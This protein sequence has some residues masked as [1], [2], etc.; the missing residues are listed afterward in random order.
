[1]ES[2][3][4]GSVSHWLDGIRR[5]DSQAAQELW[6]RYFARLVTVAR[7]RLMHLERDISGEDVALSAMKSLMMG[8]QE[9]KYPD[10]ADRSG[11][12][13]LLVTITAH[14]SISEQRRQ[15]A[16]KRSRALECRLED[17]QD[18]IGVEPNPEFAVEVADQLENLVLALD[19]STLRQI[20]EKKLAGCTN[21][22]IA[23]EVGCT[24][25]TIIRKL[26][27]IRQEW[28]ANFLENELPETLE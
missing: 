23:E 27:R 21:D 19:D 20:V 5:G 22:Q 4:Q 3:D 6:D 13:P 1:M 12:W 9:D 7:S 8:V 14:K 18:Y 17:V 15:L 11:L 10:L 26:K 28:R 2:N 24:V 25:R 16:Q